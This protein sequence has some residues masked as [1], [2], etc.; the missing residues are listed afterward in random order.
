M[1]KLDRYRALRREGLDR[2]LR[3]ITRRGGL[4][5]LSPRETAWLERVSSELRREL[6]WENKGRQDAG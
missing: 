6:G 5:H 1:T 3:K 2:L 4:E